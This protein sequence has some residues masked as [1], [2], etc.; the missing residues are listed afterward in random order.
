[1]SSLNKKDL[2]VKSNKLPSTYSLTES[3]RQLARQLKN[4]SKNPSRAEE[5]DNDDELRGSYSKKS[6]SSSQSKKAD[7]IKSKSSSS[8]MSVSST[9]SSSS[10]TNSKIPQKGIKE[11]ISLDSDDD[12]DD[13]LV[14]ISLKTSSIPKFVA[15][16][17]KSAATKIDR[18]DILS[19]LKAGTYE[20]ILLV[21]TCE[22]SHAY[23][24]FCFFLLR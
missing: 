1:M 19:T 21:D 9:G 2:V 11:I 14:P 7:E 15:E 23:E 17:P 18:C 16:A 3:G 13:D 4:K 8:Q 24:V 10:I 5:D 6:E 12:D 22:T 20:I